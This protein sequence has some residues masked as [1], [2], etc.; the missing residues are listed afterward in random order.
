MTCFILISIQLYFTTSESKLTY[1]FSEKKAHF[2]CDQDTDKHGPK[3]SINCFI[4]LLE[5]AALRTNR[6]ATSLSAHKFC[7]EE[8]LLS[9]RRTCGC[10]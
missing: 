7:L 4:T 2:N 10:F 1:I 6:M 9:I 8:T 5:L 3:F